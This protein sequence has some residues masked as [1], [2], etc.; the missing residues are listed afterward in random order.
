MSNVHLDL[1]MEKK[2]KYQIHF[3]LFYVI[4]IINI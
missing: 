4:K 1:L 2:G 3:D